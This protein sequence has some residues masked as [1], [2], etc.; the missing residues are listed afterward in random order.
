M[1]ELHVVLEL[2]SSN[3][4]DPPKKAPP[5]T[6]YG[7]AERVVENLSIKINVLDISFE[8]EVFSGSLWVCFHTL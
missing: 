2:G 3:G 8:S 6:G 5:P 1:D 7:F 4:S